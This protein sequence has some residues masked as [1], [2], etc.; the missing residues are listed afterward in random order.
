MTAMIVFSEPPKDPGVGA[1]LKSL[2]TQAGFSLAE[3][4]LRLGFT[5]KQVQ[6]WESGRSPVKRVILTG[7]AYETHRDPAEVIREAAR[8]AAEGGGDDFVGKRQR[9]HSV[10]PL[11]SDNTEISELAGAA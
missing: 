7:Y 5:R 3:M 10:T 4:A 2:R 6:N 9:E 11:I 8:I 1:Y